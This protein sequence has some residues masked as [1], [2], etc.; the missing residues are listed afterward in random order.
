MGFE[1]THLVGAGPARQ[2]SLDQSPDRNGLAGECLRQ[3]A[4]PSNA[5][6]SFVLTFPPL[7][8]LRVHES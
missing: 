7:L 5:S 2:V 6:S 3:G 1:G 8:V 4:L